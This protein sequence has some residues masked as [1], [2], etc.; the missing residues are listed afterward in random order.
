MLYFFHKS[1]QGWAF[2]SSTNPFNSSAVWGSSNRTPMAPLPLSTSW[3]HWLTVIKVAFRFL[4][5]ALMS[6]LSRVELKVA[7][8]WEMEDTLFTILLTW[9]LELERLLR[10]TV[11]LS[12][13]VS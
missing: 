12:R 4:I 6:F 2:N 5:D 11:I 9:P 7:R 1:F 13:L 10:M 8:L 3:A